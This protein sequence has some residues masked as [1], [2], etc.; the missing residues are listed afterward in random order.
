MSNK[1]SQPLK[2]TVV[3]GNEK[4]KGTV[5]DVSGGGAVGRVKRADAE[6]AIYH[7]LN[8]GQSEYEE[9]VRQACAA[10]LRP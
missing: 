7:M 6:E 4:G 1:S 3:L 10:V 9:Y 8:R 2:S 5:C